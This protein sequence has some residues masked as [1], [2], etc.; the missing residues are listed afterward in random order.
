MLTSRCAWCERTPERDQLK[1]CSA[2]KKTAYCSR[3]CQAKQWPKHRMVCKDS[4]F[5]KLLSSPIGYETMQHLQSASE[6]Y[7]PINIW[8][9]LNDT[10]R[11]TSYRNATVSALHAAWK[12]CKPRPVKITFLGSGTGYTPVYIAKEAQANNIFVSI[13]VIEQEESARRLVEKVLIAN[14]VSSIITLSVCPQCTYTLSTFLT[15][16]IRFTFLFMQITESLNKS[17]GVPIS[18]S[19]RTSTAISW[20]EEWSALYLRRS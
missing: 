11:I 20:G 18:L 10:Q 9:T 17:T 4:G 1:L 5:V 15:I 13:N 8:R 3:D 12:R 2:C 6:K 14:G 7:F 19:L 16:F